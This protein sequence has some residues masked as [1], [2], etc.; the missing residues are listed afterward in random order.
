MNSQ[1]DFPIVMV[2]NLPYDATAEELYT[3]FGTFGN[4]SQ[5]RCGEQP[6]VKGTAFVVYNNLKAAKL[7]VEK[8]SGYNFN[9]RYIVVLLYN[10][11]K[12]TVKSLHDEILRS[13]QNSANEVEI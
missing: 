11:D 5:V 4:I 7:A 2:K 9:G 13:K 8:L 1:Q 6:E 10:V 12:A 3:L